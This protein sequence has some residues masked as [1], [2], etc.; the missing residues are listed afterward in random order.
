[1]SAKSD[2]DSREAELEALR[3]RVAELERELAEQARRSAR[4]VAESQE[5]LYWLERWGVDLDRVM[6]LPGAMLALDTLRRARGVVW[7]LKRFGRRLRRR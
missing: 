3:A 1:V 7:A 2:I 6:R 4:I 5:K